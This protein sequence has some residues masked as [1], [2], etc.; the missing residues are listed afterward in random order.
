ML[1]PSLALAAVL[2]SA[3]A[4]RGEPKEG[5]APETYSYSIAFFAGERLE[6]CTDTLTV[7]KAGETGV[8]AKIEAHL[9]KAMQGVTDGTIRLSG[10]CTEQLPNR[11]LAKCVRRGEGATATA[12]TTVNYYGVRAARSTDAALKDCLSH[13]GE[14]HPDNTALVGSEATAAGY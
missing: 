2:L 10:S 13:D 7:A 4:C 8:A 6:Q 3:L 9:A 12:T 5:P 14:W 11:A 1:R